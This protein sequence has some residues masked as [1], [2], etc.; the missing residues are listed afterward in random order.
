M[1]DLA[2]EN[3]ALRAALNWIAHTFTEDSHGNVKTLPAS[4]YQKHALAALAALAAEP[5]S[6]EA[7][8]EK[9]RADHYERALTLLRVKHADAVDEA[10]A[11]AIRA[12][13]KD[14]ESNG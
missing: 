11:A 9:E 12:R 14:G 5:A 3:R 10:L 6:G 2:A 13:M 8:E 7:K 1:I 4:D